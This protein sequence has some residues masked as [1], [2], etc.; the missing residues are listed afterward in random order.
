VSE[1]LT[2]YQQVEAWVRIGEAFQR[3]I[4]LPDFEENMKLYRGPETSI[5]FNSDN[6]TVNTVGPTVESIVSSYFARNPRPVVHPT[7]PSFTVGKGENATQ[8]DSPRAARLI[9]D[10]VWHSFKEASIRKQLRSVAVDAELGGFGGVEL[11]WDSQLERLQLPKDLTD[12]KAENVTTEWLEMVKKEQPFIRHRR[13]LQW[14]FHPSAADLHSLPHYILWEDVPADI[15]LS[16]KNFDPKALK[17][18]KEKLRRG[19]RF[20]S[21]PSPDSGKESYFWGAGVDVKTLKDEPGFGTIRLYHFWSLKTR[22]YAVY[23]KDVKDVLLRDEEWP[24]SRLEGYPAVFL[25][26][27]PSYETCYPI[28]PVSWYR[29]SARQKNTLRRRMV[30]AVAKTVTKILTRSKKIEERDRVAQAGHGEMVYVSDPSAYLPLQL[31]DIPP[32]WLQLENMVDADFIRESGVT[33][34]RSGGQATSDLATDLV[35]RE[36]AFQTRIGARQDAL[37]LF[38]EDLARKVWHLW[39]EN[40]TKEQ[41]IR[42]SAEDGGLDFRSFTKDDIQGDY[43]FEVTVEEASLDNPAKEVAR[44]SQ[45]LAVAQNFQDV[46]GAE[47]RRELFHRLMQALKVEGP[48]T[49]ADPPVDTEAAKLANLENNLMLQG[50]AIEPEPGENH[51]EHGRV[52]AFALQTLQSKQEL[53]GQVTDEE[54][55]A[56]GLLMD[57]L[58]KTQQLLQPQGAVQSPRLRL[59]RQALASGVQS[60]GGATTQARSAGQAEVGAQL[61]GRLGG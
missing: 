43:D 56:A 54:V 22:R 24:F 48:D 47:G 11:G 7:R 60:P 34:Q 20:V 53:R 12:E 61:Q 36:R 3:A 10:L 28:A 1:P 55:K 17:V 26:Y 44:V 8:L 16:E 33:E 9:E 46:V 37:K 32:Q 52:H 5:A 38:L 57:H 50:Q 35:Q 49:I 58:A 2:L 29:N 39:A 59:P 15:V 42:I 27:I 18:L 41:T 51:M 40:T 6:Y 21:G 31:L 45:L 13:P 14:L 19:G 4:F 23:A 25:D 30:H